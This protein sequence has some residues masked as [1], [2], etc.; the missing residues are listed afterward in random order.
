[1]RRCLTVLACA[2]ALGAASFSPA[3]AQSPATAPH[4]CFRGRPADTCTWFTLLEVG[5]HV[6]LT[7][8]EPQDEHVMFNWTLGFMANRGSHTAIGA[9]LFASVEGEFRM[10]TALRWRRWLGP[11][12]SLDL[13]AG[14]HL[15][16]E[17][18][19]ASLAAGSPMFQARL[20]AGDLVAAT[21]RLDLLRFK[22]E[23]VA[24]PGGCLPSR[25]SPRLY[26][27]AEAGSWLGLAGYGATG[28]L[29]VIALI[30]FSNDFE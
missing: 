11:A 21:V 14:V 28:V 9:E 12:T 16:G 18:T 27:G 20:N 7:D 1:M 5:T 19:E 17:A 25:T 3:V 23:C 10:G 6:R 8:V 4:G 2:W 15:A 13:A 29:F 22:G 26:V 24:P 30:A